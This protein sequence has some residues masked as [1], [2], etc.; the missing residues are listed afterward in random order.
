MTETTTIFAVPDACCDHCRQSIEADLR[1]QVGVGAVR[2][3]VR[4][5][6]VRVS[7]DVDVVAVNAVVE[8]LERSGYPV[9]GSSEETKR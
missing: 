7:H 3:D 1:E 4:G 6:V 9:A 2:V 8:R 5:R